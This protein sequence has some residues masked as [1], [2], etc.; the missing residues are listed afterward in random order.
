MI[1]NIQNDSQRFVDTV[2]LNLK[3]RFDEIKF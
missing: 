2:L 1:S 3:D